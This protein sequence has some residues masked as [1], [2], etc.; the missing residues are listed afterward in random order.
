MARILAETRPHFSSTC[1]H[2]ADRQ[3]ILF[4]ARDYITGDLF[5][6]ERCSCCG[7]VR[8]LPRPAPADSER[9]YP[10]GYYG[11]GKRY[12]ALLQLFLDALYARRARRLQLATGGRPGHVLDIGCGPGW[13]LA[14]LRDRGW[15]TTG[16]ELNDEG[17]RFARGTLH[18]DVRSGERATATL[19][20]GSVDLIILWHVLEH[21]ERPA[22]LLAE[23]SR[24]LRPGGLLLV[25]VP[26]FG[27]PEARWARAAWFHLDVP[28]HLT[29]FD[30][31]TL[32]RLLD[33]AHLR[34]VSASYYTPEYDFFSAVQTALNVLGIR[35]NLLY[36]MLR[37]GGSR[38][39][40][41]GEFKR[42]RRG[43]LATILL[44]P[45]LGALSL[46][47][48]PLAARRQQGAT[49]TVYARKDRQ[50]GGIGA[51]PS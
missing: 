50:T 44:T 49:M 33:A 21:V 37:A 8:T 47:W 43:I 9:Y 42:H 39:L 24:L 14:Q 15:R 22:D 34:V 26:N 48:V 41:G 5:R 4:P 18:L 23:I 28:R 3:K 25:A 12:P 38:L 46:I 1:P 36:N 32:R 29:H 10:A 51:L 2:P 17:A 31:P 45:P 40:A 16:T 13:L 30:P 6:I 27:S 35:Q 7:L 19:P 11:E 20:D